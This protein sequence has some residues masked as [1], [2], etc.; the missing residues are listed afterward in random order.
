MGDLT[1]SN[2]EKRNYLEMTPKRGFFSAKAN[3]E[4]HGCIYE[5]SVGKHVRVTEIIDEGKIPTSKWDDLVCVGMI[6]KYV[7]RCESL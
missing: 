7:E 3:A 2:D 1:I 4:G 5:N 6:C